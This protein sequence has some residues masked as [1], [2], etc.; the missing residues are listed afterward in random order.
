MNM[1]CLI[2]MIAANM[3]LRPFI[4]RWL[5]QHQGMSD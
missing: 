5:T 2:L 3:W 1:R 4:V